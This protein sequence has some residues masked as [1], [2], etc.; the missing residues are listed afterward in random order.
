MARIILTLF[1]FTIFLPFGFVV[2][3]FSD[4]LDMKDLTPSWLE[5]KT[6]DLTL[7]D[8]RRLW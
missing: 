1:Y 8:A 7:E 4:L 6:G 5:R 3:L 2:S